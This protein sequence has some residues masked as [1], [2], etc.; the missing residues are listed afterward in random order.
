MT[1]DVCNCIGELLIELKVESEFNM[2]MYVH[3]F[4]QV[5]VCRLR[6]AIKFSLGLNQTIEDIGREIKRESLLYSLMHY[7]L[8]ILGML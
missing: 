6:Y 2:L 3:R 8:A 5:R 7:F 1:Y 4:N